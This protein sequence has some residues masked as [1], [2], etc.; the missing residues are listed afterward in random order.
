MFSIVMA[1]QAKDALN[2]TEQQYLSPRCLC[3]LVCPLDPETLK[4]MG[5]IILLR[6]SI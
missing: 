4:Q 2:N 6:L 1:K 3:F 5:R